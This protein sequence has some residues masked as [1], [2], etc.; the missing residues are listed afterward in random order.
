MDDLDLARFMVW[1]LEK[2]SRNAEALKSI[3]GGQQASDDD[4]T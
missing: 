1:T 3:P 4:E 2:A